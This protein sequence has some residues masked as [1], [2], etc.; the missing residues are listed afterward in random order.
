MSIIAAKISNFFL[1]YSGL[2][3]FTAPQ[4]IFEKFT[5]KI[6]KKKEIILL[7]TKLLSNFCKQENPYIN[8]SVE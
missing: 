4:K 3:T 1:G 6:S 5:Y 7:L 2:K 8:L